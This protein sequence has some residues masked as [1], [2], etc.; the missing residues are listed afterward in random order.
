MFNTL[1]RL[2]WTGAAALALTTAALADGDAPTDIYIIGV[3][4]LT[5]L[6]SGTYAGLPN[7]NYGRLTLLYA[8]Y[9]PGTEHFH[10]IGAWSYSGSRD[11]PIVRNTNPNNRIPELHQ[12]SYGQ[13]Y[14]RLR[15]GSGVFAGK[16][17]SGQDG[18]EYSNLATRPFDYLFGFQSDERVDRLINSSRGRWRTLLPTNAVVGLQLMEI[19]D[20]LNLAH[21]DGTP[22]NLALGQVLTLGTGADWAFNPVFWVADGAPEGVYS[23]GF[24]LLDLNTSQGYTPIRDSGVFYLDFYVVPEPASLLALS[25]GLVGLARLRRRQ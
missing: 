19:S 12:R 14:L 21:S 24:R 15:P 10:P 2:W 22:I 3:D 6:T 20:G 1:K 9:T 23:V 5:T 7:P 8:H 11:N 4:S 17:I 25:V 18:G 13:D 16:W